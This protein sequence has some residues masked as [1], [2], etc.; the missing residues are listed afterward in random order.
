MLIIFSLS[1]VHWV[2]SVCI[3]HWT[4][5]YS[6]GGQCGLTPGS[7]LVV[8]LEGHLAPDKVKPEALSIL[9]WCFYGPL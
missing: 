8:R 3:E 5:G 1:A 7:L 4:N 9:P 6:P 2:A